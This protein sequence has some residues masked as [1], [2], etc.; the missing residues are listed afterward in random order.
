MKFK[1]SDG[2]RIQPP[3]SFYFSAAVG[4]MELGNPVEA[5]EELSRISAEIANRLESLVF[6][7]E[8][9]SKLR[10]WPECLRI[11]DRLVKDWPG[12]PTGWIDRSF[13]LHELERTRE[14]YDNLL[15]VVGRFETISTLP[16]N[17][18]CYACQLG[19]H[20][21]AMTWFL[22]TRDVGDGQDWLKIA[23][24]DPDLEPIREEIRKM[25]RR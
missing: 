11:A 12:E 21:D 7:W 3:D 23:L 6:K 5:A 16:Y 17:L 19:D 8:V 13:A 2:R 15:S 25:A 4:W 18:A 14:A 9:Y 24:D 20:V 10:R 1:F 22:K